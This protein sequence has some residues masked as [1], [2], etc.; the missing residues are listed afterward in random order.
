[1]RVCLQSVYSAMRFCAC[2]FLCVRR[3]Y[4][5]YINVWVCVKVVKWGAVGR[6]ICKAIVDVWIERQ[7]SYCCERQEGRQKEARRHE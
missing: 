3:V 6:S 5:S 7:C 1:M 4:I 2:A